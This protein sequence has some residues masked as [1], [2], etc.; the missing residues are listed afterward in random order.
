MGQAAKYGGLTVLNPRGDRHF[1]GQ[2]R[3]HED[4]LQ[5]PLKRR[6]PTMYFVNSMSDLFH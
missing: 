1:N 3:C 2:V 6:K 4:A 5:V